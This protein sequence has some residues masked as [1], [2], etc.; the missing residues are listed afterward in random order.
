MDTEAD[1]L[2]KEPGWHVGLDAPQTDMWMHTDTVV[3]TLDAQQTDMLMHSDSG[4]I[5]ITGTVLML[6]LLLLLLL[7]SLDSTTS[8]NCT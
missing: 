2:A 3:I 5:I 4:K 8:N 6:M 7:L 1:R